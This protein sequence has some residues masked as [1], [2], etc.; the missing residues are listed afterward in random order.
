MVHHHHVL[1][2][3]AAAAS[4]HPHAHEGRSKVGATQ[5]PSD[6]NNFSDVFEKVVTKII[7][8]TLNTIRPSGS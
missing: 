3:A 8:D 5:Q 6:G 1:V 4:H 2:A 7:L